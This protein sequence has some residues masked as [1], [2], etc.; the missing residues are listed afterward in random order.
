MPSTQ[1]V[2]IGAGQAGLSLSRRLARAGHPHVVL[3]RGEIGERWRSERWD[4][5]SLHTPNWLNRLDGSP[6]HD[7]RDG[8]LGRGAFVDYL[9]RYAA[10]SGAHVREHV[11]VTAV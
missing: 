4:S 10:A 9:E 11:A 7:D 1:T 6:A 2:V 5:L 3:E 8:F